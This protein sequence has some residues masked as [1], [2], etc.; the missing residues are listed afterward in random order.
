MATQ[1]AQRRTRLDQMG[2]WR[3]DE[4]VLGR[5]CWPCW[6]LE[7]RLSAG[8]IRSEGGRAW[9]GGYGARCGAPGDRHGQDWHFWPMPG[10][11]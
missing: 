7:D 4:V 2:R 1:T 8:N 5:V 11:D 3:R 10:R 6:G 9:D